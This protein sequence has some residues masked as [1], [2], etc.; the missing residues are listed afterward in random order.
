MAETANPAESELRAQFWRSLASAPDLAI[1]CDLDGTLVPFALRPAEAVPRPETLALLGQ[2]AAN[3]LKVVIASGRPRGDLER[4]FAGLPGLILAAE[5]G[6]WLRDGEWRSLVSIDPAPLDQLLEDVQRIVG[7]IDG[8]VLERKTWG[9]AVHLRAVA[10]AYR[11]VV[12]VA[13]SAVVDAFLDRHRAFR[14]LDGHEVIEVRAAGASKRSV[15]AWLRSPTGAGPILALG[16]DATDEEMFDALSPADAGVRVGRD[17]GIASAA[18]FRLPDTTAAHAL[19]AWI[20]AV[21]QGQP[22]GLPQGLAP[23]PAAGRYGLLVVSNRLPELRTPVT[24]ERRRNVGGLVSALT[25]ILGESGGIWLGWSGRTC[26]AETSTIPHGVTI[27]DKPPLAW[28]DL[29]ESWQRAYYN[30]FC[31]SALWPLLHSFPGRVRLA[32]EDWEAYVNANETFAEAAAGLTLPGSRIWIHDYHLLLLGRALRDRG[33]AG[34]IGLFLHV[35]FCGPDLFFILPHAEALLLGMLDFD[36]IGFHTDDY[37]DNFLRCVAALPGVRVEGRSV[38]RPGRTTEVGVLPIGIIPEAFQPSDTDASAE[39]VNLAAQV[40]DRRLILG[41]D[42][43]DYTKGIPERLEAYGHLLKIAPQWRRR[44]SLVQISVPS[45]ADVIEYAEQRALVESIVGRVNGEYGDADWVPVR[46]LYRSYGTDVLGRLY[47]EA[48]VGYVTPLRDGMNLVAKEFVAAQDPAR[49]GVLLLSRFA[50]A[51]RE[52]REAVITNPY[53]RDGMA[54]D[55]ARA[56]EM[57]LEE[58]RQRHAAL[59]Q[60]VLSTTA[61]TWAEDFLRWLG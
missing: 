17:L 2:L 13:A 19:L 55:L 53:D 48:D 59:L 27:D 20:L 26:S 22:I 14:R 39:M 1:V 50:G 37:A 28:I 54:A 11:D 12:F 58:R 46:Y 10:E 4:F 34:R 7:G 29:P 56:L 24:H 33:H 35:P 36:R 25:P 23:T 21:R 9:V 16:D 3:D 47:R 41:V 52:L 44:V 38:H 6:A 51:A 5:H 30:G 57:P 31:N 15:I 60:T 43:L 8:V 18:A 49:P 61:V 40:G 42:R 32:R 45:R